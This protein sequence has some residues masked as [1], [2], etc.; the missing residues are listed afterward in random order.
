MD[1]NDVVTFIIFLYGTLYNKET[2]SEEI[3]LE[4]V[5][6]AAF[7]MVVLSYLMVERLG[8]NRV[9]DSMTIPFKSF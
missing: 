4:R 3:F 7:R 2:W 1:Q 6:I 5:T 8:L 9:G